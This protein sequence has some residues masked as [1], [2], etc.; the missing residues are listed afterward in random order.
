M[1]VLNATSVFLLKETVY[2]QN[3]VL[4]LITE[5]NSSGYLDLQQMRV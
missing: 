5:R 1:S 4:S 3:L 2:A